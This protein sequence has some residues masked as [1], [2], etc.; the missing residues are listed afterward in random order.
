MNE[1]TPEEEALLFLLLQRCRRRQK[2]KTKRW[3]PRFCVRDIFRQREQ[4]GEYSRLVW[5]VKLEIGKFILSV[6]TY[7]SYWLKLISVYIHYYFL[8]YEDLL[9]RN[10]LT[11]SG[12]KIVLFCV[13]TT[14]QLLILS[15]LM[16]NKNII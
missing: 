16:F 15:R 4:Y 8:Y 11:V 14:R 2:R 12:E 10:P 6:F 9:G 1:D 3:K 7:F 13:T 5:D